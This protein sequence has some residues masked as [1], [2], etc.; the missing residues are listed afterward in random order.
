[1]G[2]SL[3]LCKTTKWLSSLAVPSDTPLAV[4]GGQVPGISHLVFSQC[5][6][7]YVTWVTVVLMC[8][9][10]APSLAHSVIPQTLPAPPALPHSSGP[11]GGGV[12]CL[13]VPP[14]PWGCPFPPRLPEGL[15]C[16]R[17]REGSW[18]VICASEEVGV[19]VKPQKCVSVG[20]G[21][22]ITALVPCLPLPASWLLRPTLPS[23]QA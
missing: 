21:L 2:V 8:L 12:V 3:I 7:G 1:M 20:Q 23:I 6:S 11:P 4:S 13:Q 17:G 19:L 16:S 14:C 5:A 18:A 22:S 15:F 10:E 9:S